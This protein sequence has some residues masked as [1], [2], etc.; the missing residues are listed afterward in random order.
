MIDRFHSYLWVE[1]LRE[2]TAA[3]VARALRK[4]FMRSGHWPR[5]MLSDRGEEFLG[6]VVKK[7]MEEIG[8]NRK[9]ITAFR[10]QAN[11]QIERTHRDINTALQI[12]GKQ[13]G[14]RWGEA[15]NFAVWAHNSTPRQSTGWSP[16]ELEFGRRPK[17]PEIW[18]ADIEGR[19]TPEEERKWKE[20]L[21]KGLEEY[22]SALATARRKTRL[23]YEQDAGAKELE[24]GDKVLLL[25]KKLG[26]A[27]LPTRMLP[28]FV[29]PYCVVQKQ[30]DVYEVVDTEGGDRK[31]VNVDRMMGPLDEEVCRAMT[32][33]QEGEEREE[34]WPQEL[35]VGRYVAIRCRGREENRAGAGSSSVG[36]VAPE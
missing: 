13:S 30:N 29:G 16:Y 32:Q 24:V 34:E 22:K 36:R 7:M 11:G 5:A 25:N 9:W 1:E 35:V 19:G 10:P 4:L 20:K 17:H 27:E 6:E 23:F 14:S 21:L 3:E 8:V 15:L 33:G 26:S 12:Y 2:K 28:K 18:I 31:W